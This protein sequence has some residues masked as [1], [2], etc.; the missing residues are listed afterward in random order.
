MEFSTSTTAPEGRAGLFSGA[1]RGVLILCTCLIRRGLESIGVTAAGGG[2]DG[3]GAAALLLT[4]VL[5]L[6][7]KLVGEALH[8]LLVELLLAA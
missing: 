7:R 6:A 2:S 8:K 3:V 4:S 1:A 5:L